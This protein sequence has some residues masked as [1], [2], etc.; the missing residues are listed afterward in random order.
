MMV[1]ENF[2]KLSEE[3]SHELDCL[4]DKIF[5]RVHM[6]NPQPTYQLIKKDGET[7]LLCENGFEKFFQIQDIL[8]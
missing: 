3:K 5:N 6:I 2:G 1:E 7:I 8:F 4:C